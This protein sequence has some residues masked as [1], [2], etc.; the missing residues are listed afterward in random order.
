ML[1]T[2]SNFIAELQA[3]C[4]PH[5]TSLVSSDKALKTSCVSD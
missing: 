2:S 1:W 5:L 3:T 4:G